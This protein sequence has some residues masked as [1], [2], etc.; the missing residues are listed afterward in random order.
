GQGAVA[1]E[2]PGAVAARQS[3][4]PATAALPVA[5]R[6]PLGGH[7]RGAARSAARPAAGGPD[8]LCAGL[9]AGRPADP[10][11]PLQPPPTPVGVAPAA[12]ALAAHA[13]R[14]SG[15][16]PRIHGPQRTETLSWLKHCS[17][18]ACSCRF[19]PTWEIGR[20]HV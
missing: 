14:R 16:A 15:A 17:G 1:P 11:P 6:R 10:A 20:A 9:V 13:R 5:G 8:D 4:G 2:Q 3:V 12:A 18:S 7:R 19:S